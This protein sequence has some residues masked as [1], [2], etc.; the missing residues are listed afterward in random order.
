[1]KPRKAVVVLLDSLNRQLLGCYGGT[2]FATP[3]LDRF[4][5]RAV[6]FTNHQTGSLPCMPAR[7]DILVG[8]M[9][10]L[11]R[12]WGSIEL[13][14][15]PITYYLRREEVVTQLFTDHPHLFEVGGEN[16]HT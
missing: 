5:K 16:Y 4:A 12:P 9:D 2:E 8:A 13:W 1:M 10:F 3:N 15:R 14:E 7:H 11:W 6:K